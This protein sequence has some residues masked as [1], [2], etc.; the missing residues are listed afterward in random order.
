MS[1]L[2]SL[3]SDNKVENLPSNDKAAKALADAEASLATWRIVGM[4]G[5]GIIALIALALI[6][7]VFRLKSARK[8]QRL[9]K[10]EIAAIK[11]K[12]E[13]KKIE[14]DFIQRRSRGFK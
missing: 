4:V 14:A 1:A 2:Q 12:A 8:Y 5:M 6:I 13:Q 3:P 9:H 10:E 7:Y 11:K